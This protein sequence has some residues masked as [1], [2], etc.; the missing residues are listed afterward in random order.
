[1]EGTTGRVIVALLLFACARLPAGEATAEAD[2][3]ARERAPTET[4]AEAEQAKA[5]ADD[6]AAWEKAIDEDGVVIHTRKVEGQAFKEFRGR[7][8]IKAS[9]TSLV[10]LITD[11]QAAP[12]WIDTCVKGKV[13]EQVS[14]TESYTYSLNNAPWPVA[15]RDAVVHNRITQ[16]PATRAVTITQTGVPDRIPKTKRVVRVKKLE[17]FW[18]LTPKEGGTVE[19]T[20]QVLNDPGGNLPAWLVNATATSQPFKTLKNMRT[21]VQREKYQ[22]AE[23]DFVDEPAAKE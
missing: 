17:G 3:R 2:E 15:D 19:V 18:R 12:D 6:E 4:D 10:A 11:M 16:D 14:P 5:P 20:Y 1:M 23:L 8:R 9:L 13:L 22:H 7:V 21:V